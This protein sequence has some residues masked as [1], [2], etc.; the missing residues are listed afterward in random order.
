M[1]TANINTETDEVVDSLVATILRRHQRSMAQPETEE[2]NQKTRKT[3]SLMAGWENILG[4]G[5][6]RIFLD[7]D[8]ELKKAGPRGGLSLAPP[9]RAAG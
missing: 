1:T 8:S 5:D 6:A 2:E 3:R 7:L 4:A 9:N